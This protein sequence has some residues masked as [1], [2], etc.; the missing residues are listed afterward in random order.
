MA[1]CP[2][3]KGK[4]VPE[5]AVSI[6]AARKMLLTPNLQLGSVKEAVWKRIALDQKF[7][8]KATQVRSQPLRHRHSKTLLRNRDALGRNLLTKG[9]TK[10]QLS[11]A[12]VHAVTWVDALR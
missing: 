12:V 3:L 10:R 7:L 8:Y 5:A 1:V 11:D 2:E 9:M 4:Q 6:K